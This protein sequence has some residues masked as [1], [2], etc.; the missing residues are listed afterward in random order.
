M[1]IEW[2]PSQLSGFL[3]N[4]A[5]FSH[6][7]NIVFFILL[8]HYQQASM[9]LV[10]AFRCRGQRLYF[11]RAR[12]RNHPWSRTPSYFTFCFSCQSFWLQLTPLVLASII[13]MEGEV[14]VEFNCSPNLLKLPSI[15][16]ES[17][18]WIKVLLEFLIS[19]K[20][21]QR[22]RWTRKKKLCPAMAC[23]KLH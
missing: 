19:L 5:F 17:E 10:S 2:S 18:N 3:K 11:N 22:I 12:F 23:N 14:L 21:K 4:F 20:K 6:L 9:Q 8:V 1:V 7:N 16:Y 13:P 15:G